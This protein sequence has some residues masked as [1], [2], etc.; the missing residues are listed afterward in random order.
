MEIPQK[1]EYGYTKEKLLN[2][3]AQIFS[4]SYLPSDNKLY[5]ADAI[6]NVINLNKFPKNDFVYIIKD[7][8][9]L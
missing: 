7:I 5:F 9:S 1:R 3:N 8:F 2:S 6:E 4:V